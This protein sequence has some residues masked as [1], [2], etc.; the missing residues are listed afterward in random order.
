M[1]IVRS[2]CEHIVPGFDHVGKEEFLELLSFLH[3]V[4]AHG[5]RTL[6]TEVQGDIKMAIAHHTGDMLQLIDAGKR[7]VANG[8]TMPLSADA[9][10]NGLEVREHKL[11]RRPS[12]AVHVL[13]RL[14]VFIVYRRGLHDT[15]AGLPSR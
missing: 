1:Y 13:V 2:H 11:W 14:V 6:S 7:H 3:S 12:T 10:S 8:K 5:L 15:D 9:S 4:R